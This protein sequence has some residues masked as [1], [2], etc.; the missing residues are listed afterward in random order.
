MWG[1]VK[2]GLWTMFW[3]CFLAGAVVSKLDEAESWVVAAVFFGILG[4]GWTF[5]GWWSWRQGHDADA[6]NHALQ[7]VPSLPVRL[8]GDHDDAWVEGRVRCP[9]PM[10]PP[11]FRQRCSWFHYRELERQGSGERARWVEV[12]N[13]MHGTS[14]WVTGVGRE[15]L[16]DMREATV[17]FAST[18]S[19]GSEDRRFSLSYM[20]A[21]GRLSVCGLARYRDDVVDPDEADRRDRSLA[22]WRALHEAD[23]ERDAATLRD[24][25]QDEQRAAQGRAIRALEASRSTKVVP[26]ETAWHLRSINEA[27]GVPKHNRMVMTASQR[28]PLV[29]T[30]MARHR[31]HDRVEAGETKLRVAADIQLG[32]GIPALVW[33]AGL[34]LGAWGLAFWPGVAVGV[35]VMLGVVSPSRVVRLYNQFVAYRQR[36]R[37]ARGDLDADYQLRSRL[38]PNLQAV[39]RAYAEHE[40]RVQEGLAALRADRD[41]TEAL[42][43]LKESAPE[44]AADRNFRS[45]ADDMTAVEERIAFGRAQIQDA[46]AEYNTLIQR[47]PANLLAMVCGFRAER[48]AEGLLDD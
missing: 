42:F 8:V 16:V 6:A 23:I 4:V 11:H 29:V 40:R 43:A 14:V 26:P 15:I 37:A 10:R 21:D 48:Q 9:Q 1:G 3:V 13:E 30:P 47:F 44:L 33:A 19:K 5:T 31:W 45:L 22:E 36:V 39:V 18:A 20:P 25:S 34:A 24:G 2:S 17:H 32:L 41:A 35:A 27:H 28:T 46:I 12:R 7:R 38:L